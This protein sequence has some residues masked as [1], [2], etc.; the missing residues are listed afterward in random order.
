LRDPSYYLE[1]QYAPARNESPA[2]SAYYAIRPLVPRRVQLALRRAHAR[3]RA[4]R[5]FPAWPIEP[6]LEDERHERFRERL[7]ATGTDH[8]PFVNFWPHGHRFC[9]VLTHDVEGE[10][11]LRN[12]E[13]V[14][15]V[16]RRHGFVSAWYLV[17]EEYPIPAHVFATL[18][19]AGCEVG[20]HGIHHNGKLFQN[21]RRFESQ[22]PTIHRYL[23]EWDAV[24]FRSPSLH[25][26]AAWM[27]ELGCLYDSSF[28]DTDPFEPQP[29]GCCSIFPYLLGDLVE[30]PITLV[31]DHTLLEILGEVSADRWIDKARWLIRHHG[32]INLLVHPDYVTSDERLAVY[33][34]FLRFLAAQS[35][36]W[37][38]LPR[39][40]AQWWR[41]RSRIEH[42]PD[43]VAAVE[44]HPG[45]DATIAYAREEDEEIVF[46]T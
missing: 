18:R 12:L 27:P 30:L 41:A 17:A 29:G 39:D 20:L 42:D 32:L 23:R 24:G 44:R 46:D 2:L 6:L 15:D 35:R 14:L 7:H 22:L 16:E 13:R 8:V 36:G 38:A 34:D 10:A 43:P 26:N 9:V 5:S 1:E 19:D 33:D 4:T 31:Q 21:R 11:G 37:H 3:R 40:V 28:P 45:V 25:R